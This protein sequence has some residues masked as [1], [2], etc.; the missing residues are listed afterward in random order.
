MRQYNLS[1]LKPPVNKASGTSSAKA[2][3]SY[4][5]AAK[6]LELLRQNIQ[7]SINNE[8]KSLLSK[9]VDVITQSFN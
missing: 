8:I 5:N 3:M 1:V 4:T 6:S 9:Y 2:S 7:I